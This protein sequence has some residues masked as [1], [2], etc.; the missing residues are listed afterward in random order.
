MI[1]LKRAEICSNNKREER[2]ENYYGNLALTD[3]AIEND[4]LMCLNEF[5]LSI[6]KKYARGESTKR[7]KYNEVDKVPHYELF[8]E[9]QVGSSLNRRGTDVYFKLPKSGRL[10]RIIIYPD[11]GVEF[12]PKFHKYIIRETD[13]LDRRIIIGFCIKYQ[14]TLRDACYPDNKE[15]GK[16]DD[17]S[18]MM[19][20]MYAS[21]YKASDMPKRLK[22]GKLGDDE[23]EWYK[24]M[25]MLKPYDECG[26]FSE[27]AF[28]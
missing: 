23:T 28:I 21:Y 12:D 7:I 6:P 5:K 20:Q 10:V 18:I 15:D 27:V 19:M 17:T 9:P 3:S 11:W 16:L 24:M 13:E 14:S 26:M 8:V 4:S 22:T 25:G 1:Y 2:N